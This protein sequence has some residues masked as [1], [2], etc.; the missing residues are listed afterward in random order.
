MQSL[1]QNKWDKIE[2]VSGHLPFVAEF[3]RAC[4]LTTSIAKDNLP[5]LYFRFFCDKAAIALALRIQMAIERVK[6]VPEVGANQMLIDVKA[7]AKVL[8]SLPALLANGN[9]DSEIFIKES[10]LAKVHAQTDKFVSL[11]QCLLVPEQSL[12]DTY[13]TFF[14]QG[15]SADLIHIMDVRGMKRNNQ[16]TVLEDY[17]DDVVVKT[18]VKK[19][20]SKIG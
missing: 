14:P 3:E 11:V 19:L 12:S 15:N 16:N 1:A 17:G 2:A 6:K 18:G 20:L 9:I 10:F 4:S 5:P 13:K 8:H 7:M